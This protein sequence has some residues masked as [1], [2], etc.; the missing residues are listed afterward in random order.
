MLEAFWAVLV[1]LFH[2]VFPSRTQTVTISR[3]LQPVIKQEIIVPPKATVPMVQ[4]PFVSGQTA[5]IKVDNTKINHRPI[6]AFDSRVG[7]LPYGAEV[8]V[9]LVERKSAYVTHGTTVGWV[10]GADVT[11][12]RDEV[13]PRLVSGQ[14]YTAEQVETQLI[15]AHLRDEC[16]GGTLYLPLQPTEYILYEL[17]LRNVSP[18]WPLARPRL[19]GS[20]QVHLKGRPRTHIGV[21][22]KTSTVMEYNTEKKVGMLSFVEAVHPDETIVIRSV[23]KEKDGQYLV[24]TLTEEA[25]QELRPVFISCT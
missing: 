19:P 10:S 9:S 21:V 13:F 20:W 6:V 3:A 8:M 2:F 23:G 4:S 17:L 7:T 5:F 1:D 22:P 14:V 11:Y 12:N 24:E 18:Q 15:R 25:W 16:D